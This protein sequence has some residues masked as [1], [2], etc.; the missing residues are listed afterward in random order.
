MDSQLL[1]QLRTL[2]GRVLVY[3]GHS[4][5]IVEILD[6]EDALV[7]RCEDNER[8]IQGNQF[9]EATRLVQRHHTVPLF[10][11]QHNLNPVVRTWLE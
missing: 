3:S 7:L 6:G 10:D 9:G 4:C 5:R 8:V 11:E 2:I 1:Q